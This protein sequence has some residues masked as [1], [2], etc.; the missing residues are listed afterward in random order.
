MTTGGQL[1]TRFK[2]GKVAVL[3]TKTVDVLDILERGHRAWRV[4]VP[5]LESHKTAVDEGDSSIG[6]PVDLERAGRLVVV[7]A[8]E[9]VEDERTDPKDVV[10][11]YGFYWRPSMASGA[12]GVSGSPVGVL[13]GG[14]LTTSLLP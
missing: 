8:V 12:F 4:T 1:S 9:L 14:R 13:V 7:V 5:F 3:E 10:L 11:K 6:V 2:F